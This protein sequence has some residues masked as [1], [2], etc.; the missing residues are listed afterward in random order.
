MTNIPVSWTEH[1]RGMNSKKEFEDDYQKEKEK[2]INLPELVNH[3]LRGLD[4][5]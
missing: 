2:K 4:G 3:L 1:H 5:L